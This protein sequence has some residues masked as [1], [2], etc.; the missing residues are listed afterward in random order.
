MDTA[1]LLQQIL[2]DNFT[3]TQCLKK[4]R[5]LK[6]LLL[7]S[8]F[9]AEETNKGEDPEFESWLKQLDPK[10]L[11][12][13]NQHNIYTIFNKLEEQ[14]NSIQP[15]VVYLPITIPQAEIKKLALY[16]RQSMGKNFLIE[17]KLDP[18]LIAG[19]AFV[20]K[21]IYRDYSIRARINLNKET[22]L[23]R[24]NKFIR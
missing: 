11:K 18:D 7:K 8:L 12:Q 21:G 19:P 1:P 22:I 15:L 4:L 13:I 20:W 6:E 23:E 5:L 2:T 14:I 17:I 3:Q 24:L 16:L 9:S 10:L